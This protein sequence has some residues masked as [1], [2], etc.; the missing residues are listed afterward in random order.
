MLVKIS[1]VAV[2]ALLAVGGCSSAS[3]STPQAEAPSAPASAAAAAVRVGAAGSACELPVSFELAEDWEPKAVDVEALGE[4]AELARVG[5]F[6]VRCEV[7][8]KPAGNIGFLRV[9]I[10]GGLSGAPRD[11]L[12]MFVKASA[13]GKEVS[14]VTYSDVQIG[15]GQA[16]E[17]TWESYSKELDHPSKYSAF[18]LNTKDG[19]MVVQL[20]PFGADEHPGMLP[21]FQLAE[22]T[23]TI[24]S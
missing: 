12:K 19:A 16:A 15:G 24:N 1:K 14:G 18:A 22:R 3:S 7:D 9:H 23:L 11:H 20:S 10:A 2:A 6:T 13:R 8:A 5:V 17:V 21:A 4:L